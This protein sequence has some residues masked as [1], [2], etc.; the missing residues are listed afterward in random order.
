[1][2]RRFLPLALALLLVPTAAEA[3]DVEVVTPMERW[4]C[5]RGHTVGVRA[6][7]AWTQFEPAPNRICVRWR[8]EISGRYFEYFYEW[9]NV[10]L[11]PTDW[12]QEVAVPRIEQIPNAG[13][14]G[15]EEYELQV[16]VYHVYP[17]GLWSFRGM[18]KSVNLTLE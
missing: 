4:V 17:T 8:N 1:M 13:T 2:L 7:V 5:R 3:A 15:V 6:K 10:G 9:P 16:Q 12:L 11:S 18:G 14:G